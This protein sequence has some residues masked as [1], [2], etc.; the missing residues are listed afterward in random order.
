MHCTK[1]DAV[2]QWCSNPIGL[3]QLHQSP[4]G[5]QFAITCVAWHM[6]RDQ[7]SRDLQQFAIVEV[8]DRIAGWPVD[9]TEIDRWAD[10][11]GRAP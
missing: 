4:T 9:A 2:V 1:R 10:D 7:V 6:D 5:S 3:H 11:G 8:L